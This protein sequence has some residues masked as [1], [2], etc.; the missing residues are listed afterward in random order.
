VPED[1]AMPGYSLES[2]CCEYTLSKSSERLEMS[3]EK[4]MSTVINVTSK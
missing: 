4:L 3:I 1:S 2:R